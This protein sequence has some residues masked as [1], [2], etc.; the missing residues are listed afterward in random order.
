M[1]RD[2]RCHTMPINKLD[3]GQLR[4]LAGSRNP[5]GEATKTRVRHAY[6]HTHRHIVRTPPSTR[7]AGAVSEDQGIV[8]EAKIC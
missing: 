6:S 7:G 2:Y 5:A 4:I 1:S 8:E 3:Q